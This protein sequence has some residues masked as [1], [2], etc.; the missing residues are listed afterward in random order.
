MKQAVIRALR[1]VMRVTA[2]K[3]PWV[4]LKSGSRLPA[5]LCAHGGMLKWR[6]SLMRTKKRRGFRPA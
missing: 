3:G 5:R 2:K 4:C 6:D 1:A